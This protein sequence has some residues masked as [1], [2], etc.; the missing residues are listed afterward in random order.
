[1]LTRAIYPSQKISVR[2]IL[3]YRGHGLP[4]E[5]VEITL[6]LLL[7]QTILTEPDTQK[8]GKESSFRLVTRNSVGIIMFSKSGE[9]KI[10]WW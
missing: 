1:M 9:D 5:Y 8:T 4:S 2:V 3:W 10:G 6:F 7:P